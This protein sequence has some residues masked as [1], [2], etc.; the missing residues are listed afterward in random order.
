MWLALCALG[1]DPLPAAANP[2]TAANDAKGFMISLRCSR[3]LLS[4]R[5]M[6]VRRCPELSMRGDL[7]H[8]FAVAE[9]R[10]RAVYAEPGPDQIVSWLLEESWMH[11]EVCVPSG[12]PQNDAF[13]FGAPHATADD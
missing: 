11:P 10:C 7:V 6:Y 2:S 1:A 8:R 9:D 5:R 13:L 4:L 12:M 3:R